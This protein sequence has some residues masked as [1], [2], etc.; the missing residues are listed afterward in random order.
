MVFVVGRGEVESVSRCGDG[1]EAV[2]RGYRSEEGWG[3]TV[4][5]VEVEGF[6]AEIYE[7]CGEA[8]DRCADLVVR[9]WI[10]CG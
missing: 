8:C 3:G 5:P 6:R 4:F 1:G 10:G 7:L 9:T 2:V